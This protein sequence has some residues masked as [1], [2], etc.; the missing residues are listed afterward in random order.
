[1][2]FE[3]WTSEIWKCWDLEDAAEGADGA[4]GGVGAEPGGVAPDEAA[5]GTGVDLAA[6]DGELDVPHVGG[7]LPEH[8][9]TL[10]DGGGAAAVGSAVLDDAR[11]RLELGGD[12]PHLAHGVRVPHRL[13]QLEPTGRRRELVQNVLCGRRLLCYL[14]ARGVS[15]LP[16]A[17]TRT[18]SR[19]CEATTNGE[20]EML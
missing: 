4:L 6:A 20:R 19:R 7:H 14:V 13:Q 12:H 17:R 15:T 18:A 3:R 5:V 10:L 1:L 8:E 11:C 9:P 16:D 2:C